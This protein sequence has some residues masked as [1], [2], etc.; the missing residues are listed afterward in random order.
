[1]LIDFMPLSLY[2]YE[3]LFFFYGD[4]F[5]RLLNKIRFDKYSL[6]IILTTFNIRTNI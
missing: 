1:M 5:V 6:Q 3:Y 4:I 2:M